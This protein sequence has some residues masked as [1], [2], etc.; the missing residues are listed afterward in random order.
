M[1]T[2][3]NNNILLNFFLLF[4]LK[5]IFSFFLFLSPASLLSSFFLHFFF[6]L[7]LIYTLCFV[8]LLHR[9]QLIPML[10]TPSLIRIANPF[11]PYLVAFFFPAMAC[12]VVVV[13]VV[14]VDRCRWVARFIGGWLGCGWICG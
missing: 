11:C 3:N 14:W 10:P 1:R 4:H 5:N 6:S 7:S 12:G 8:N 13:V 9:C 2:K